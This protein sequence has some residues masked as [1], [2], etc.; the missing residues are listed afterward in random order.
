MKNIRDM[1]DTEVY[2]LGLEILLDKLGVLAQF[3]SLGSVSP[4]RAIIPLN[5]ISG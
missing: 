2:E 3:G 4:P 5:V 1:T